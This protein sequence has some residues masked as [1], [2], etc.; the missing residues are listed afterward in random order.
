MLSGLELTALTN[1]VMASNSFYF[2]VV[3]WTLEHWFPGVDRA[4]VVAARWTSLG[5]LALFVHRMW[6]NLGIFSGGEA[7]HGLNWCAAEPACRYAWWATEFSGYL[8]F[9]VLMGALGVW[10]SIRHIQPV[11]LRQMTA[12]YLLLVLI[13]ASLA[14]YLA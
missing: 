5:P 2:V 14:V 3:L 11:H 6:W 8:L 10:L 1:A 12:V 4:L 9:P 7:D 13:P